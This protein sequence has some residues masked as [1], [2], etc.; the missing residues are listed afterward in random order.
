MRLYRCFCGGEPHIMT[1]QVAAPKSMVACVACDVCSHQHET[2]LGAVTEWN[3]GGGIIWRRRRNNWRTKF[4]R[5]WY[6]R[7]I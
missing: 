2:V 1:T 3:D 7:N 4:L 5:W 6:G